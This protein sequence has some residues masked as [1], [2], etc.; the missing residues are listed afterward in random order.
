MS[1]YRDE[2]KKINKEVPFTLWTVLKW[3]ILILVV[4][5]ILYWVGLSTGIISRDIKREVIQHSQQYTET[6][7]NLLNKL[8]DDWLQL[9]TE[10]VELKT[11]E[12]NDEIIAA[13][14]A[15]QKN[16]V[17]RIRREAGMIPESQVPENVRTFLQRH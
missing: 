17:K 3:V 9:D 4:C 7:G 8:H 13:K 5:V 15:Q 14:K 10:I 16:L 12:G 6:K 11:Y 2:V 1:E